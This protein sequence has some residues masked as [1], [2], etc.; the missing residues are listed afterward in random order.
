[1]FEKLKKFLE[2]DEEC[3]VIGGIDETR[4]DEIERSLEI[5]FPQIYESFLNKFGLLIGYGVDI[6]G[7]GKGAEAS[8]VRETKRYRSL[9]LPDNFIV[10]QNVDE[11]VYCLDSTTGEVVSWDR[12]DKQ[13]K[14]ICNNFEEYL[15]SILLEAKK[16]WDA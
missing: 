6:L 5:V 4:I 8:V 13:F 7:C 2:D 9:G 1:M 14:L 10:I 12:D 16:N 11:W 15:C 3:F